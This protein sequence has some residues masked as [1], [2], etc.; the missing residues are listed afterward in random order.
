MELGKWRGLINGFEVMFNR[1]S[2]QCSI[3]L[4]YKPIS[5]QVCIQ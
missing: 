2:S 1:L 3:Y 4:Y 5:I